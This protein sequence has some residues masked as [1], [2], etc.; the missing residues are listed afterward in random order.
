[1]YHPK[2]LISKFS[3]VRILVVGDVMLDRY[4]FG[5]VERISPEAPVPIAHIQQEQDR[6][7]GAA[8]VARNL[9]ALGVHTSLL[10]II[11]SDEIGAR[12]TQLAE[13]SGI[14]HYLHPDPHIKTTLK[15]RVLAR[16]QQ[17]IRL[18]FEEKP[19]DSALTIKHEQFLSLLDQHD[20]VIFS[21]Y[22]KGSL[23]HVETLIQEARAYEK[24]TMVDPKGSDYT[25]YKGADILTPNRK[26]LEAITG[27]WQSESELHEQAQKLRSYLE[28]QAILLTRSEEGMSLFS[29]HE[30]IHHPTRAK[31]VYDVSGAGDTVIATLAAAWLSGGSLIQAMHIANIAAGHVVG[32]LGT[33]TCS[34]HELYQLL[35]N[36]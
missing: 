32:K 33:A 24:K 9:A 8:N 23:S 11:G 26:E 5:Q 27:P 28:L 16:Q 22:G 10:S 12:I 2:N 29:E 30:S 14:H 6:L 19:S 1:M 20:A 15:L 36:E 4:W 13:Q 17:I 25:K 34:A 21:D 3:D 7:G 31:E 35:E 18:D